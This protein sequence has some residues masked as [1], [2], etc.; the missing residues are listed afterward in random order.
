MASESLNIQM[1]DSLKE[2]NTHFAYQDEQNGT[3]H[4]V[5]QCLEKISQIGGNTLILSGDVPF[6]SKKTL[7]NLIEIHIKND[8]LGSLISAKSRSFCN[9]NSI[10]IL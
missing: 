5:E 2:F 3:A 6:I 10:P 1:E 4:A 7:Q 9:I 8:S